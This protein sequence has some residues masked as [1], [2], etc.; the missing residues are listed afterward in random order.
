MYHTFYVYHKNNSVSSFRY[1]TTVPT[2]LG[3][4]LF[5]IY[6]PKSILINANINQR[7]GIEELRPNQIINQKT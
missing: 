6:Q 1:I 5:T 4:L 2:V 3:K 7:L